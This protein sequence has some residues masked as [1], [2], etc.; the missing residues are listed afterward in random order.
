MQDA[1]G[2]RGDGA[3]DAHHRRGP[4][5]LHRAGVQRGLDVGDHRGHLRRGRRVAVHVA[6]VE[7]HRPDVHRVA[8]LRHP[9]RGGAEDQ[10]GRAAPDVDDEHVTLGGRQ[11]RSQR[12]VEG[13][14]RLLGA[15][16]DLGTHAEAGEHAVA[17]R[18]RVGCV[19][20]RR[21]RAE[22][23]ALDT[24]RGH[25]SGV[26]LD[27][28]EGALERLVREPAGA[29]DPLAQAHHPRLP[30]DHVGHGADEQLDRV[31]AA[32][33]GRDGWGAGC[34]AG[35]L[36]HRRAGPRRHRGRRPTSRRAA[37]G[38]RHPAG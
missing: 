22:A 28:G 23:D 25:Q 14:G 20:G 7:A 27:R 15:A 26:L 4:R 36:T 8:L 38:P 30:D 9:P 32:V 24:V 34:G 5:R 33:D 2:D 1:G 3:G 12:A 19:P 10:L 37:R 11:Q 21:R 17:E 29:V 18:V 6:L 13:E 16:E 35:L 31:G